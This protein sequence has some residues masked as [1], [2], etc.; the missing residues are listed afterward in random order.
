M[1]LSIA[2]VFLNVAM[3]ATEVICGPAV[4]AAK[5]RTWFEQTV[6]RLEKGQ[7]LRQNRHVIH[8]AIEHTDSMLLRTM[9]ES[10]ERSVTRIPSPIVH[11]YPDSILIGLLEFIKNELQNWHDNSTKHVEYLLQA[12]KQVLLG[13]LQSARSEINKS[14]EILECNSTVNDLAQFDVLVVYNDAQTSEKSPGMR[15]NLAIPSSEYLAGT[16][17]KA[18]GIR[19]WLESKLLELGDRDEDPSSSW[20][21]SFLECIA[22]IAQAFVNTLEDQYLPERQSKFIGRYPLEGAVMVGNRI[23]QIEGKITPMEGMGNLPLGVKIM[24][25]VLTQIKYILWKDLNR[26]ADEI[27][28]SNIQCR[29]P[30]KG[31]DTNLYYN[32]M[33][34]LYN[35][36]LVSYAPDDD[37]P[38]D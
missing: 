4:L 37:Q 15:I 28:A 7:T 32:Y 11:D 36:R 9:S 26:A 14:K 23:S 24:K 19:Q 27:D 35:L 13:D 33:E 10:S 38:L 1:R 5:L 3:V 29:Y 21:S 31:R 12:I 2:I 8:I 20:Y 22:E 16:G 17:T 30:A 25:S 34:D 18:A 6:G